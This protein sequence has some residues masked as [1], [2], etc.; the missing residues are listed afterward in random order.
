MAWG[1]FCGFKKSPLYFVPGK[2]KLDAKLYRDEILEPILIPFWHEVCEQY[3]WVKVV[4]DGAP[5]H[6]GAAKE[7]REQ[8]GVDNI[9]WPAQSPDLNLIE[10]VWQEMENNL[11][12]IWGRSTSIAAIQEQCRYVWD[13]YITPE[14][15]DGL[16]RSMPQRIEAVIQANG[17]ATPY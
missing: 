10:A 8:C 5:G 6:K 9:Q 13:T 3:G 11:G 7:Y 14:F 15:L 12:A 16:I 1:G 17:G 4:E 2:A